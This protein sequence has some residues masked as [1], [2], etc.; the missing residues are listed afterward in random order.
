MRNVKGA[1][2]VQH[3]SIGK[4]EDKI[5]REIQLLLLND[6]TQWQQIKAQI[7]FRLN[8][9]KTMGQASDFAEP[10]NDLAER[11]AIEQSDRKKDD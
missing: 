2:Q 6:K 1:F 3:D 5:V 10:L 9:L 8:K 11:L 7:V 4:S